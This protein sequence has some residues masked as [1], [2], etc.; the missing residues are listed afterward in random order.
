VAP[1]TVAVVVLVPGPL[2]RRLNG[3]RRDFDPEGLE[4]IPAHIPL[5]SPFEAEPPLQPLERRCWE[6]CHR[7]PPFWVEL[8][9]LAVDEARGL[10]YT[11]VASGGEELTALR[12]GLLE[13]FDRPWDEEAGYTPEV[14]VAQ[15]ERRLDLDLMRSQ[16]ASRRPEASFYLERS[17]LMARYPDGTWYE[18]DFYTLDRAVVRA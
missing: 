6:V 14:V 4:R 1:L 15:P 16:A 13:A 2:G 17:E 9:A 3:L 18:R 7:T 10:L 12:N 8:G 5:V 11:E